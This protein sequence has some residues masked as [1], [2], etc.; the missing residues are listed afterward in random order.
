M[1]KSVGIGPVP[2][3]FLGPVLRTAGE[4]LDRCGMQVAV[5]GSPDGVSP[6]RLDS[7]PRPLS[8]KFEGEP[9]V[10]WIS[11]AVMPSGEPKPADTKAVRS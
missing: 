11:I 10:A 6:I 8:S 7:K 9:E 5:S 1:P 2:G 4:I 3:L